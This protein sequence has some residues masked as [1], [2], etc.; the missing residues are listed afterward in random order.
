MSIAR[1]SRLV[2]SPD[3]LYLEVLKDFEELAAVL[4]DQP[5]SRRVDDLDLG[6]HL[7]DGDLDLVEGEALSDAHSRS[8]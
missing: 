4:W 1:L 8:S 5:G 2:L 6:Q 7:G 3:K